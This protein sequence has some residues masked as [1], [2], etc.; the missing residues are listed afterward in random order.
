MELRGG[1]FRW[2]N[3][4]RATLRTVLDAIYSHLYGLTKVELDY[5]LETFPIVKRKDV[6]RYGCYRRKEMVLF[7]YDKFAGV[8][9]APAGE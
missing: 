6:E 9:G 8:L 7:Y 1:A 3:G 2:N 4:K 5:I